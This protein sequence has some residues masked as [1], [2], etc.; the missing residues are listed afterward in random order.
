MEHGTMKTTRLFY[1]QVA[2]G[3]A[4]WCMAAGILLSLERKWPACYRSLQKHFG[5][6]SPDDWCKDRSGEFLYLLDPFD[7]EIRFSDWVAIKAGDKL[8]WKNDQTS[9][10]NGHSRQEIGVVY[11]KKEEAESGVWVVA[12]RLYPQFAKMIGQESSFTLV[13]EP[14]NSRW[15]IAT[16]LPPARRA[17]IQKDAAE[18]L[19]LH[20]EEL[21]A[22][23]LPLL[24]EL[25]QDSYRI[26]KKNF[27]TFLDSHRQELE[28]HGQRLKKKYFQQ[29]LMPLLEKILWPIAAAE[30][31]KEL[32]PVAEELWK[33]LPKGE[34]VWLWIYQTLPGVEKDQVR[35]RLE[36]YCKNEVVAILKKH[37]S[38]LE[39][40]PAR[41]LHQAS[42]D[43]KIKESLRQILQKL[44]EDEELLDFA[45]NLARKFYA[46][47]EQEIVAEWQQKWKSQTLQQKLNELAQQLEPYLVR[48]VNRILLGQNGK[49]ISSELAEVLRKQVLFKDRYCIAVTPGRPVQGKHHKRF[50]GIYE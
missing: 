37:Q 7:V 49:E 4:I 43:P 18:Y 38:S 16:L 26:L 40:V 10:N 44:L 3:V 11:A 34:L 42:Q 24:N 45:K 27:A 46:Q 35:K 32:E 23:V 9:K 19:Q 33:K 17:Q 36:K 12:A 30:A 5:D 29:E 47:N 28:Q 15:I 6:V 39:K 13:K 1:I 2:V 31:K 50:S 25:L 20:I 21:R 48:M 8:Y 14:L 22:L 41:I